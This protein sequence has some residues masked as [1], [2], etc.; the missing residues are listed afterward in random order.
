MWDIIG[1]PLGGEAGGPL[2]GI[3]RFPPNVMAI[4]GI[5]GSPK[6]I[7]WGSLKIIIPGCEGD[8]P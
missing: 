8:I 4:P 1:I 3:L 7:I 5:L 6:G 2:R